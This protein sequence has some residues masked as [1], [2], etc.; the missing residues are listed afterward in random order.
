MYVHV[1]DWFL[2]HFSMTHV[3][4]RDSKLTRLLQNALGGNSMTAIICTITPAAIEESDSTLKVGQ[5][6]SMV[7]E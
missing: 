7:F 6:E 2:S 1:F 4:F 5:T 3:S